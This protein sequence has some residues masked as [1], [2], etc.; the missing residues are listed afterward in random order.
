MKLVRTWLVSSSLI[1]SACCHT[2]TLPD[3]PVVEVGVIDYPR[4]EVSV[5]MTG[6][7]QI[8]AQ[9]L[10]YEVLLQHT[11][12]GQRKPLSEYHKAVCFQPQYW[13]MVQNYIDDLEREVKPS[14]VQD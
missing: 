2:G 14:A 12:Q 7:N 8:K 4:D 3:K 11:L 9:D 6:G 13:E 5:N 10:K 1:L